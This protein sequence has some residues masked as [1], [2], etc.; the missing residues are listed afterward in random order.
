MPVVLS[1]G[2]CTYCSP[3]TT[4]DSRAIRPKLRWSGWWALIGDVLSF[5]II[6]HIMENA[7]P[8]QFNIEGILYEIVASGEN[9]D[10]QLGIGLILNSRKP[11]NWI[12]F[13]TYIRL[14]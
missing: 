14:S 13:H 6:G 8:Q 3:N 1:V 11:I 9:S 7:D 10:R 5:L 2:C 4:G 12:G